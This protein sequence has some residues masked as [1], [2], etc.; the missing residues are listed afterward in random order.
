M[1]A[2]FDL[3]PM[4]ATGAELRA[5]VER[6]A[7]DVARDLVAAGVAASYALRGGLVRTKADGRPDMARGSVTVEAA[8][9]GE[10][11]VVAL[12]VNARTP[13]KV[14]YEVKRDRDGAPRLTG[15]PRLATLAARLR[16]AVLDSEA[17]TITA[18]PF[19]L[20]AVGA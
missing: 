19:D 5:A 3:P 6:L 16:N 8:R 9:T 7:E 1:H 18:D 10:R 12:T 13:G 4:P 20:P 14:A 15:A 2:L 11:V 17:Y